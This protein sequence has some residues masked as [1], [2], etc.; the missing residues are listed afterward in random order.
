MPLIKF[1]DWRP[2]VSD[3][4]GQTS[5]TIAGVLPRGDGYGPM[6]ASAAYS[7]AL[8]GQ[9]RGAFTAY[10][11][12]GSVQLFAATA[13]DLYVLDNNLL[14]WTNVSKGGVAYAAVPS[15]QQWQFTQFGDVVIAVQVNTVPQKFSLTGSFGAGKFID[16]AGSPPNARYISTVGRFVVLSGLNGATADTSPYTVR[17]SGLNAY[18]TWT[19]GTNSS[20]YQQLPDGGVVRG[21]AGG[22]SGLIFQDNAIRRMT[23]AVGSAYVFLIERISQD[24]GL[25]APYSIIRAGERIFFLSGSGFHQIAPGANYPQ[26]IGKEKFDRYFFSVLDRS[27]LQFIIGAAD[28]KATRVFWSFRGANMSFDG[29]TA[30]ICYD[31]A[32]ERA[33][34]MAMQGEYLVQMAQPGLTLD[35][36]ALAAILPAVVTDP[37]PPI[38]YD[39]DGGIDTPGAA[40]LDS[41]VPST[42]PEIAQ[43]D[44]SH[45]LAFFGGPSLQAVLDTPEEGTDGQR[46]RVKGLRPITDATSVFGSCSRRE[47]VRDPITYVAE[48]AVTPI[49]LCPLNVSTRYAR[50]R[51]RIPAAT[52]WT[53][54]TGVEP[55][56]G[57]E[58]TK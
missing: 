42:A 27:Q 56:F 13:T 32:L 44:A 16:V 45:M 3:Y 36:A 11:T 1:I 22:E 58:G 38:V 53:Y 7:Q 5:F 20:D 24:R 34:I 46:L 40:S 35:G 21:V 23:W 12:D 31:Y 2:D 48:S 17:W 25:Y 50:G 14:T 6:R 52:N 43:F 18:E 47:T 55:Q 9:C 19:P 39:P 8:P 29:Y 37:G 15:D 49:G 41:Y 30:L 51:I 33:T 57:T 10:R 26:P 28:P 54:A 4:E